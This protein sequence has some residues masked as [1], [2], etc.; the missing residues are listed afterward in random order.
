MERVPSQV[1]EHIIVKDEPLATTWYCVEVS[2]IERNWMEVNYY[3]TI[4]PSLENYTTASRQSKLNSM[5]GASWIASREK[6][7]QD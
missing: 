3:T 2:R 1:G 4:T 6:S 5:L 7:L